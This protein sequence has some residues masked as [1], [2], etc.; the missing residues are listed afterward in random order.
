M[1]NTMK[2]TYSQSFNVEGRGVIGAM[3]RAFALSRTGARTILHAI[4]WV[5][6][7][8]VSYSFPIML[9]YLFIQRTFVVH[10]AANTLLWQ[11]SGLALVLLSIMVFAAYK[12][13]TST[14]DAV[15]AESAT[16]RISLAEQLRKIPLAF[17]DRH[18]ASD[19]TA[20][21]MGDTAFLEHT[22]SH[23]LAQLF[24][25]VAMLLL[26][27]IGL[28]ILDWRLTLALLGVAPIVLL[29]FAASIQLLTKVNEQQAKEQLAVNEKIEEGLS[30]V[31]V[32]T[33]YGQ[34]KRYLNELDALQ[35]TMEKGQMRIEL[36]AGAVVYV[37]QALIRLG[38]PILIVVGTRLYLKGLIDMP[39]LL[40]FILISSILFEPLFTIL[41]NGGILAYAKVKVNRMNEIYQLPIQRGAT[42]FHPH[43]YTIELQD[44]E[45][46]YADGTPVLRGVSFTAKQGE[47]TALIGPSGSGK[48]TCARLIARFWDCDAGKISLG[49]T[50]IGTIDP[51]TLLQYYSIVFQDVVL[52]N[53]SVKE[54]IRMGRRDATD[55]EVLEAA[56][57]ARCD[58]FVHKM[59]LG[60]ETLIGENGSRLSGGERQRISIARAIL[61][62]APIVILDE[63]TAS[64]DAE[65]ET[66]IQQALSH[67]IGGKTVIIIAHRMRTIANVDRI[68]VLDN[69]RVVESGS[70]QSLYSSK[71]LYYSMVETQKSQKIR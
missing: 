22:Y 57:L 44:V 4:G 62:N 1:Y 11:L 29:L 48:S 50:D 33:S 2:T 53:N 60:Y 21:I 23:Q 61:K 40:F 55:E 5:T 70:P 20:R 68:V 51:E 19:I 49:G 25:S 71:G 56:R 65:N 6:F 45:F 35:D 52:F 47:I 42:E 46:A 12:S 14:F 27:A 43:D 18:N 67:L 36:V 37:C 28:N 39:T 41:M 66:Q 7:E 58:G 34:T 64:Q 63:A 8:Y 24:A 9:V 16:M 17:Y 38:L 69:G 26:G 10:T 30:N 31:V 13:Y 59:P 32:I 15:Y 3:Q 54:N